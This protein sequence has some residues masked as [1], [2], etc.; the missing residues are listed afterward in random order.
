MISPIK[1]PPVVG[2]FD[3]SK[4]GKKSREINPLDYTKTVIMKE[5]LLSFG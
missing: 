2:S 1:S 5:C 3:F 4:E